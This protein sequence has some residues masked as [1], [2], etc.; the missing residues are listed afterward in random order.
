VIA[1]RPVE[2]NDVDI[3]LDRL[4]YDEVNDAEAVALLGS[5]ARARRYLR[6]LVMGGDTPIERRP[7]VVAVDGDDVVGFLD[8]S[9]AGLSRSERLRLL[10][11]IAGPTQCVRA[12]PT[13][14]GR[15]LVNTSMPEDALFI[16]NIRVDRNRRSQGIGTQLLLCAEEIAL[17]RGQ[18]S[19][20][21]QTL[22]SNPAIQLYERLGY[23]I[24]QSRS[25]RLY[26][27][28]EGRCT[29]QK[30]L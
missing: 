30:E 24:T 12:V 4:L 28:G 11:Q 6:E 25:H 23:R 9:T 22:V 20:A 29:M 27:S 19:V 26:L 17:E 18:R 5:E 15:W 8:Y 2:A 13:L 16:S 14:I 21:L 7:Y 1:V 3:I 10:Y